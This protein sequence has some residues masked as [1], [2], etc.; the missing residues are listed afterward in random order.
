MNFA[1]VMIKVFAVTSSRHLSIS[2]QNIGY[3]YFTA[4]YSFCADA[5]YSIVKYFMRFLRVQVK[6]RGSSTDVGRGS[7]Q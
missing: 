1:T 2:T 5:Y 6:I 7:S 3:R 4:N